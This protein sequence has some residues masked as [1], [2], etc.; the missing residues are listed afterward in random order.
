MSSHMPPIP[1]A[2][3]S[4]AGP[5]ATAKPHAGQAH[6]ERVNTNPDQKG[7]QANTKINTTHQGLQQDR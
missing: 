5:G 6:A 1:K 3:R 7:Q 4:P 2:S